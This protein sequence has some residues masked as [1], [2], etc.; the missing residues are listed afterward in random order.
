[1]N[2]ANKLGVFEEKL[3]EYCAGDKKQ[4]SE[5]LRWVVGVTGLTRKSCIKR[6]RRLQ[7]KDPCSHDERGRPRYYTPDCTAALFSIRWR[8]V[9]RQTPQTSYSRRTVLM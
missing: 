1:M 2:M 4:K 3:V 6:F 9:E 7:M 8:T 5:I